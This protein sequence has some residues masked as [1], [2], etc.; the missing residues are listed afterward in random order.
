[1]RGGKTR[2]LQARCNSFADLHFERKF[3]KEGR[4]IYRALYERAA[5]AVAEEHIA[6]AGSGADEV[7]LAAAEAGRAEEGRQ[8][9]PLRCVFGNP[10]RPLTVAPAWRTP[11]VLSLARSAYD[12]RH[13]PFGHLDAAR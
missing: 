8:A 9:D 5:D 1:M 10:F 11:A 7:L 4:P 2:R 13:L 3:R 6:R 12:D